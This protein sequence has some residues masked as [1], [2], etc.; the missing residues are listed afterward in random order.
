MEY[1]IGRRNL[2]LSAGAVVAAG[3]TGAALAEAADEPAGKA[4]GTHH[5][6]L[7]AARACVADGQACVAHCLEMFKSGDTSLAACAQS[8]AQMLPA[9]SAVAQLAS[10]N[11]TRLGEFATACRDICDDCE[12]E[13]RKHADKHAV[14]KA[15]ADSCAQFVAEAKQLTIA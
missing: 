9:C 2:L 4:G 7:D 13:C 8:V 11:A 15:C 6:L 14:C 10:L 3:V 1:V 5:G 12:K